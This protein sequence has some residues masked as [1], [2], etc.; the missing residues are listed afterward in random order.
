MGAVLVLNNVGFVTRP[1]A[2]AFR[3]IAGA[4]GSSN[5]HNIWIVVFGCDAGNSAA[6]FCR[7]DL[8][9]LDIAERG[10]SHLGLHRG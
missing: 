5:P 4:A 10:I 8:S 1:E 7:S 6:H 9:A 2:L 3:L